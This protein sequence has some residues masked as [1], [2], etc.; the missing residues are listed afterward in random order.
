MSR[1]T[2]AHL[3]DN[4]S[5]NASPEYKD[6]KRKKMEY[7]MGAKLIEVGINPKNAVYRWSK[8]IKGT[9]EVWTCHA[10]WGDSKNNIPNG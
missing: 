8:E 3:T 5:K 7:Y 4:W 2:Q 10:Y 6:M 9:Q 1:P